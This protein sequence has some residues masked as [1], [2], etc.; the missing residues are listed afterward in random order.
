MKEFASIGKLI[1]KEIS[2]EVSFYEEVENVVL[3]NQ[4]MD[5]VSEQSS[6]SETSLSEITTPAFITRKFRLSKSQILQYISYHFF[7]VDERGVL[8]VPS[9]KELADVVGCS[10]RTI[11]NNNVVLE[12]AGLIYYSRSDIGLN[13]WLRRYPEYFNEGGSGYLEL[14]YDRFKEFVEIHNVNVLRLEL[15]EELIYD[16]NTVKRK[17]QKEDVAKISFNDLKLFLPKYTHYKG[18]INSIIDKVTGAFHSVLN[19]ST[20]VF[21]KKA[22][23]VNG[24]EAKKNRKLEYQKYIEDYLS[25]FAGVFV[26]SDIEDFVQLSFE[27]GYERVID[28]LSVLIEN[29]FYGNEYEVIRNYG[30]KVRTIIRMQL[31][32]ENLVE[33]SGLISA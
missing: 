9:E 33:A 8:Y 25:K 22:D 13:I 24:K 3:Q 32:N 10:V 19:G 14:Q 7:S 21:I 20:L 17:Y 6:S 11:R 5:L 27:Y 12:S 29:V 1:L 23:Y 2:G 4:D 28:A 18:A 31:E 16:N 30:G 15:R 26:R